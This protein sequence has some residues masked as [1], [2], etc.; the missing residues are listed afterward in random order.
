MA[1]KHGSEDMAGSTAEAL[2]PPHVEDIE[3]VSASDEL[4]TD[5]DEYGRLLESQCGATDDSQN[6]EQY[7]GSLG[8]TTGFVAANQSRAGQVQWNAN[9]G[10]VYTTAGNV[11]GVRWGARNANIP[12]PFPYRG[13]SL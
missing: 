7:D 8:V 12:R 5:P 10:A 6:V 11:S 1:K 13:S 4:T 9:L 2:Y 3:G